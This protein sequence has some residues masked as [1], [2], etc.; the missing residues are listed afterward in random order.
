V[1]YQRFPDGGYYSKRYIGAKR[2]I[3]VNSPTA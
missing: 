2:I 1:T 3:G